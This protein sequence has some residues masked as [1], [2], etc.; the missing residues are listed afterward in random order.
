M[1]VSQLLKQMLRFGCSHHAE[2]QST[3][4]ILPAA[5]LDTSVRSHNSVALPNYW[6]ERL[7]PLHGSPVLFVACN[8]VGTESGRTFAGSSSVISMRDLSLLGNLLIL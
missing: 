3:L 1:V 2:N 8:R 5:W 6:L 7:T 4:L